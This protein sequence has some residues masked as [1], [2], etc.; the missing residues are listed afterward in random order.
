[1][2]TF[3]VVIGDGSHPPKHS[4][5]A[6]CNSFISKNTNNIVYP[7]VNIFS[8]P[9]HVIHF[10][11]CQIELLTLSLASAISLPVKDSKV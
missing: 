2:Q 8:S 9:L 1:M 11:H 5:S 10:H 3:N 7:A 6:S 4:S